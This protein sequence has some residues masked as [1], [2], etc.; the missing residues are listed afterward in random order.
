MKALFIGGT[1]LIS[2]AV[3][4]L[5]VE[6]GIDLTLLNR[7]GKKEF[8]PRG[9]RQLVADYADLPS[10]RQA[11]KDQSYDVVANWIAYTPAHAARDLELFTGRTGQYL[12]ISSASAYQ[13]PATHWLITE[14]T[15]LANPYWQYSRDKIACEELLTREYREKGF[16]VTIVRPSLT[17]GVTQ[18]PAAVGSWNHPWTLVDRMRRGRRVV[19]P[20]DGTSLWTLTHN[21][22]LA[23]GFVGLMGNPHA[24]GHAFHITSDE[25][26]TW[27]QIYGLIADAAGAKPDLVHL[28]SDFIA[29]FNPEDVGNLIGDK[30]QCGVFDNT[31]IKTFVPGYVATV[32]F[33]QGIRE[34]VRWFESHP[35]RCTIDQEFNTRCDRMIEANDTALR[36]AGVR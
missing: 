13:K 7:G 5:A 28:A 4:R 14:S 1:G 22:D 30:A 9:A 20:G 21:S 2:S 32:P 16:P 10:V 29:A 24:I 34:S 27:N 36:A 8:F 23:R 17:Y 19:V 6:R 11:L 25:V 12:F 35:D 3:S 33:A 26:L 18:I 31:K 15:P